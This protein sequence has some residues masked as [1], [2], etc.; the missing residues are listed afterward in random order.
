M[1]RFIKET[2]FDFLG[3]RK[4][5]YGFSLTLLAIT[6]V[7]II[8][9]KGF[10]TS[11]EFTGGTMIQLRFQRSVDQDL[12]KVR[13][14]IT[15]LDFG[16]PEIKSIGAAADNEIQIIVQKQDEGT[17]VADAIKQALKTGYADN[18]F[19]LRSQQKVGP[20]IGKELIRN[21]FWAV[22]LSM[23]AIIIYVWV[24]FNLPYG[25]GGVVGLF[26]D[27]FIT[28]G[29]FSITD[30]EISLGT[31]A[32]ILTVMGYSINDTIVIFDRVRENLGGR[33]VGKDL[34][35]VINKSIN[36]CLSR[37]IITSSTVLF[38]LIAFAFFG[39]TVIRDFALA[40]LVGC[41]SGVYSTVYISA[42]IV[43]EW[44]KK[45]PMK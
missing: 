20:K 24:R 14:I 28:L 43:V 15:A 13:T 31:I 11:I 36:Q 4:W 8:W 16:S 12:G 41:I 45:W 42:A 34:F 26:H 33:L 22:L 29:F 21:S 3:I 27:A 19:E 17:A 25:F 38:V 32:A 2:N 37:T 35:A 6:A 9:H 5:A 23:I 18:P 44:H 10:N 40:L 39:G 1:M 30:R 7:S